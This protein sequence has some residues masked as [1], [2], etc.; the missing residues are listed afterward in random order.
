MQDGGRYKGSA[1][2]PNP[3]HIDVRRE[4]AEIAGVGARNVSNVK[5][6]LKAAHPRLLSALRDGS[7]TI[8]KAM[9]FC[10]MPLANQLDA[11]VQLE[12]ERAIDGEIRR[13]LTRNRKPEPFPDT[14]SILNALQQCES[15]FPGSVLVKRSRSGRMVVSASDDVLKQINSQQELS[16]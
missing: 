10:K 8:N 1:K 5:I 6:I 4:I 9:G 3:Q 13:A 11:F 14:A 2:L 12:E 7:L 16:L 15:Q